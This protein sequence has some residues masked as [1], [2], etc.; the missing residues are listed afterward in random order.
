MS[1][2]KFRVW[3][4]KIP[5]AADTYVKKELMLNSKQVGLGANDPNAINFEGHRLN[6]EDVV[7]A[8]ESGHQP[9]VTGNEALKAVKVITAIYESARENGKWIEL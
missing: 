4:F 2:D 6:F 3:D 8:I 5:A 9:L 7:Q 1:D